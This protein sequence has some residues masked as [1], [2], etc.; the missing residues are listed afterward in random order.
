MWVMIIHFKPSA[1]QI[2][3]A[4]SRAFEKGDS[5]FVVTKSYPSQLLKKITFNEKLN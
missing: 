5:D 3:V 1:S 2:A 4:E